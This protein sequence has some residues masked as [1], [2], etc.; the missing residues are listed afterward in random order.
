MTEKIPTPIESTGEE[1]S[2]SE[3]APVKGQGRM[4]AAWGSRT[5]FL[6]ARVPYN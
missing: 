3:N 4:D 2:F 6:G 1:M 5:D